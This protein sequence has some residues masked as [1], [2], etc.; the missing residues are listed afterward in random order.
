ML[1]LGVARSCIAV[2]DTLAIVLTC[3]KTVLIRRASI[4]LNIRTPLVILL[5]RDGELRSSVFLKLFT[6][7]LS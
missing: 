5:V 7:A 4:Q 6:P 2:Y 1:V 3:Y